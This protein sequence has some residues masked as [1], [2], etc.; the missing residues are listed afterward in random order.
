M[1]V[2]YLIRRLTIHQ[3]LAIDAE[4]RKPETRADAKGV[5]SLVFVILLLIVRWY[6]GRPRTFRITFGSAVRNWPFP[7]IWPHVYGTFTALILYFV[8]PSLFIYFVF[9]ERIQDHG[10]TLKG[11]GRY[12]WLYLA[13]LIVMLPL[14]LIASRS[15]SFIAKYPL[16]SGA[17][18]SWSE[19]FIYEFAYGL[20]FLALEFFFRGFMLFAL[21]RYFGAYAI[22]VMVIPYAMIHFGKPFAET[23]G[24]V[25]A[26][27][28]LGTLALRTRSMFNGLFIHVAVAWSM[29]ILAILAK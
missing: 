4:Y 1:S 26:G 6:Y 9:R 29:D 11:I 27:T 22:F 17:G 3:W 18:N 2:I 13:M 5:G 14:L 15:P 23:V 16:Y 12:K 24:S 20:Y 21:A 10:F 19:F 8:V 7:Q 28:A 25:I